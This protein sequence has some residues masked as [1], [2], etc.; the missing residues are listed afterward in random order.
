MNIKNCKNC[1]HHDVCT[2][3]EVTAN[4]EELNDF[5]CEDY[6]N[7]QQIIELPCLVGDMVYKICPKCNENHNGSCKHCAWAGCHVTGCDIGVRIYGDGSYNKHE[8]QI[9][10]VKVN[11]N[12]LFNTLEYWNIMFFETESLAKIAMRQYDAIRKMENKEERIEKFKSWVEARDAKIS[13]ER[14]EE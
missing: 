7:R 6:K 2:I 5:Y 8:L 14:K 9:V 4:Q 11:R 13:L 10:P 3:V 12:N 1:I